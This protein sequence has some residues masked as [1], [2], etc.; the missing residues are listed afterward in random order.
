MSFLTTK[1]LNRPGGSH[2]RE[3]LN[4]SQVQV[5]LAPQSSSRPEGQGGARPEHRV[6]RQAA[7]LE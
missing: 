7:C 6:G 1:D 2:T 5:Q 4:G 3:D